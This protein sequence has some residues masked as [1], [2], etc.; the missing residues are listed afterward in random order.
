MRLLPIN[1]IESAFKSFEK[2]KIPVVVYLHPRD[3]A[4]EQP[5]VS[6]PI[7]RK[8]KS[9]VGLNE[10]YKKL[11]SWIK[12]FEFTDIKDVDSKIDWSNVP[13]LKLD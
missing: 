8:F 9:Y 5:V 3:F 13:V 4:P 6:M 7:H 10:S 11:K 12:D 2:K 1:V